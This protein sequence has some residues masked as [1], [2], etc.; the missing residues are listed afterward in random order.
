MKL[1]KNTASAWETYLVDGY[2]FGIEKIDKGA[3]YVFHLWGK[4]RIYSDTRGTSKARAIELLTQELETYKENIIMA[5]T[6]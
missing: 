1:I 5:V 4:N 6:A 2:P 3:W